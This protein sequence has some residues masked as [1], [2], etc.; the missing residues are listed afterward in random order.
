MFR[1]ALARVLRLRLPD[2]AEQDLVA[3]LEAADRRSLQ[4][5]YELGLEAGVARSALEVRGAAIALCYSAGQLTDDLADGDC[6]YLEEPSR[7]GPGAQFMLQNLFFATLAEA[8][9]PGNAIAACGVE[10]VTGAGAQQLEVRAQHW[11]FDL[12]YEVA[13]GIS[14]RQFAAYLEIL[15][16]DTR[17]EKCARAVGLDLGFAAHVVADARSADPRFTTLPDADRVRLVGTARAALQRVRSS[18]LRSVHRPTEEMAQVL[19]EKA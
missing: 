16:F 12:A 19:E 2:R 11:T 3:V 6:D 1:G 18:D 10:L 9:L 17:L 5:F 14:G 13:L 8:A 4:L 7:T 15:W